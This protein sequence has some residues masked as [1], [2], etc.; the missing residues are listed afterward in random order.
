MKTRRIILIV[1]LVLTVSQAWSQDKLSISLADARSY[2]LK[3]NRTLISAG[4]SL[5]QAQSKIWES[6]SKG[7]PQATITGLYQNYLGAKANFD[8]M[9]I[10]FGQAGSFDT[11]INQMVFNAGYFVGLKLAKLNQQ[12]VATNKRKTEQDL[13]QQ[14]T[15]SYYAILVGEKLGILLYQTK[16]NLQEILEKTK[17]M[18]QAG[19][20]TQ[21]DA[22]QIDVQVA[23]TDDMIKSNERQVE[24]GYNML[25]IQ[26]GVHAN[27][28]IVLTDSISKFMVNNQ[29]YDLLLQP[30]SVKG[31]PSFLLSEKQ[32][33]IA[34]QQV[35][36]IKASWLPTISAFYSYTYK[37]IKPQ[38]DINPKSYVGVQASWPL[39]NSGGTLSQISQAKL[40]AQIN[41]NDL[42]ALSDQLNVQ[43]QQARFN[44]KNAMDNLKTQTR[45]LEV[46][47]RVF[48][49]ITRK[50]DHGMASSL[51]I[52]NASNNLIQGET[53]YVNAIYN[54]LTAQTQV[55][56]LLNKF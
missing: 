42:A 19:A 48:A 13:V 47:H 9:N 20:A 16:N 1:M 4:L 7:L 40:Q 25:R 33:E 12:M 5:Q 55:E 24:L 26:L 8:G 17:A 44:L 35:K 6:V 38:F 31:N 29:M 23:S 45:S 14:V 2:A 52:T 43:D 18:V 54:L 39:F 41:A 10:N 50:H 3:Y 49:D 36:Q 21:T 56:L 32:L 28:Q 37:Y 46:S 53:N 27:A 30:F 51:D 22:D 15:S 11:Q 34:K